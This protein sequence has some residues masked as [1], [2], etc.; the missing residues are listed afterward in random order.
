M[1][2]TRRTFLQSTVLSVAGLTPIGFRIAHAEN[3]TSP[4]IIWMNAD[5]VG[6]GEI[7]CYGHPTIRT[8]HI[9]RLAE[10]GVRFTNAFVTASSCS[11]SRCSMFTGKYPHSTGAEN[12]HDPLPDNQKIIATYLK[13]RGYYSGSVGKFHM[14]PNA[15]KQFDI[16]LNRIEDWK[17]F[18]QDRPKDKPFFLNAGFYDAHR[19]F[20]RGC[21][22]KPYTHDEIVVPPYLPD[23]PEAREELAGFYDEITRMDGVIGEIVATL[24]REGILNDTLILF[25]GDNGM[26]FPRAKNTLYDS[27]IRAPLIFYY[28]SAIQPGQVN[29]NLASLADLAPTCLH[30]AGIEIPADME[31]HSLKN[32]IGDPSLKGVR[33][34]FAEKN[35]HDFDDHSRAIRDCRYK[36]IRNAFPEK[37]LENSA[38]STVAPLFQKMRRMRD[39]GTLPPEVMQLFRSRRAPEELYDLESDPWEFRNL[40]ADPAYR[41]VLQRMS[42]ELD[43]WIQDTHDI[44]PSKAYPDE[45]HPET[46]ERIRPPHQDQ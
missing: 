2:P 33:Y 9:D 5:D 34:I 11:P 23:I 18:L 17:K 22:D 32:E 27:G 28:P 26:P 41:G 7:G 44:S 16:V 35:W 38:D 20:D 42:N 1:K 24:E 40:A 37:P 29:H 15:E 12:L 39:A 3:T 36:Y 19:P 13:D 21:I 31:G 14:G 45:F 4:N 25:T 6:W 10:G 46:G 43:R 8:P 30:Y